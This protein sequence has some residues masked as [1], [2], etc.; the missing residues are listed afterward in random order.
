MPRLG[1]NRPGLN[2]LLGIVAED[3]VTVVGTNRLRTSCQW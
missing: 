2:Q 3:S 1:E